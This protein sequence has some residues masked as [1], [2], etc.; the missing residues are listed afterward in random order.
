LNTKFRIQFL[1]ES[2]KI[3][4]ISRVKIEKFVFEKAPQLKTIE[5]AQIIE[6]M[7]AYLSYYKIRR[8]PSWPEI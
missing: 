8:L 3:P 6:K 4:H 2:S 1:K 5:D 7:K